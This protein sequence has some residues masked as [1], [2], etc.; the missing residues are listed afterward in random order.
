MAS[1]LD[2][3]LGEVVKTVC[4]SVLALIAFVACLER[5]FFTRMSWPETLLHGASA[6]MLIW[7]DPLVNWMG[8]ALFFVVVVVQLAIWKKKRRASLETQAGGP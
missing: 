8:C 3:P 2:G 5:F 7:A 4:F 6:V 1:E